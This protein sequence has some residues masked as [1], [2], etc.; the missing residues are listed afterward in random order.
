M[1][2]DVVIRLLVR[3]RRTTLSS[4]S[5]G[6]LGAV[7]LVE[8]LVAVA[9]AGGGAVVQAAAT[10]A[11]PALPVG[12]TG[13]QDDLEFVLGVLEPGRGQG[14]PAVAVLSGWGGVGKTTLAHAAG[15]ASQK[16][17]WY[18]GVL[19]V[20]LHGYDPQPTLAEDA[21]EALLRSLGVRL[22]HIPPPGAGR[23]ALYR[24][25]LNARQE[26]GERLLLVA[27]NASSVS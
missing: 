4:L 1:L 2:V 10:D 13:R 12:F 17:G 7:M 23:E 25:Q 22:E 21:L 8:G 26:A 20:D 15:H 5:V 3:F 14:G 11:L 24:S 19:L 27:D 9:A 6:M 16:Q 18:T